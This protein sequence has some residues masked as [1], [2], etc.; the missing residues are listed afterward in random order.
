MT[1]DLGTDNFGLDI[2]Y[3]TNNRIYYGHGG[4]ADNRSKFNNYYTI[5]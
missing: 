5:F 2:T 1:T 4:V 3:S